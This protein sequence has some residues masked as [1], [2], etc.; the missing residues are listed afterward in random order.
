MRT[1]HLI[2][3]ELHHRRVGALL[4]LVALTAAVAVPV[5]FFTAGEASKRE[6]SRLMRDLGFNL[7]IVPV[8]T[9]RDEFWRRGYSART[10]P[11]SGVERFARQ[12]GIAYNH[13]IAMLQRRVDWEGAPVIV[14]GIAHE[15]TPDGKRKAPMLFSVQRGTMHVGA[16]PARRLGLAKYDEVE[17]LGHH[18]RVVDC[19]PATGS[20]D[21]VRV[22]LD[23]HDA[24]ELLEM[25]GRIN[26]IRAL[27]CYCKD[28]DVDSL[29]R[30]EEELARIL[31][32]GELI[33]SEALAQARRRQRR[34]ADEFAAHELP[35]TIVLCGLIIALLAALNVRERR[36]E[37]GVLRALGHGSRRIAGL[38]LG[39]ALALG[40]AAGALGFAL[41]TVSAHALGGAVFE[42]PRGQ[43]QTIWLLLPTALLAAPLFAVVA[44]FVPTALAVTQDPAATLREGAT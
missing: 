35:V 3:L 29:A 38:F 23:L 31:P 39:R 36:L 10:M 13:L 20:E 33:R 14:T 6:T 4:S 15:V 9:D 28:P 27:E 32:E 44:S 25:P 18:F 43:V 19:L 2:L 1:L 8:G 5:A 24:Q 37:I 7:R 17:L 30:L 34:M 40:V 42:T 41:G 16:E 21:D 26:E 12:R 22:Y 11:D